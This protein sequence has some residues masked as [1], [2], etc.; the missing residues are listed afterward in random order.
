MMAKALWAQFSPLTIPSCSVSLESR[1]WGFQYLDKIWEGAWVREGVVRELGRQ[2]SHYRGTSW[3]EP[4][5][6]HPPRTSY[7][8]VGC[9]WKNGMADGAFIHG[10]LAAT[11]QGLPRSYQ[12]LHNSPNREEDASTVQWVET[13]RKWPTPAMSEIRMR[14]RV[15]AL[16]TSATRSLGSNSPWAQICLKTKHS[17]HCSCETPGRNKIFPMY[18][19]T[20]SPLPSRGGV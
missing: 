18:K 13:H 7:K 8:S 17:I 14:A 12:L 11:Y 19:M 15:R 20:V 4:P 2:E 10:F 1:D 9:L 16:N 6:A 5:H 3:G